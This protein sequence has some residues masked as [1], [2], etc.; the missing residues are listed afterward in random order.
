MVEPPEGFSSFFKFYF[1][2]RLYS[3][4]GGK[5]GGKGL[6]EKE[7]EHTG[8]SRLAGVG[9]RVHCAD[10]KAEGQGPGAAGR[11]GS[12]AVLGDVCQC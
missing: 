2:C 10:G 6:T 5:D 11:T 1:Q 3:R 12:R 4:E 7:E 9:M 8:R